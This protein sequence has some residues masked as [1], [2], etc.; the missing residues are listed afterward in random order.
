MTAGLRLSRPF[1]WILPGLVI[2]LLALLGARVTLDWLASRGREKPGAAAAPQAVVPS[3]APAHAPAAGVPQP[4]PLALADIPAPPRW[5]Q[6]AATEQFPKLRFTLDLDY[7]APLGD[8][9]A[10]AAVWFRDFAKSDGSRAADLRDADLKTVRLFGAEQKVYPPD[11]PLLREAEPWVD[12]ATCRFYPGIWKPAGIETP[13][14]NLL[15]AV[16]LARSWAARGEQERDPGRAREDFRRAIRLGRLLMQDDMTLIQ[17]LVGW[18]CVSYGLSGLNE[19]ARRDGDAVMVAA[20]TLA[21]GDYNAMRDIASRWVTEVRIED[22]FREM[23]WGWNVSFEDAQLD[24][25]IERATSDSLRCLRAEALLALVVIEHEGT[26]GQ[27][28]KAA[29]ALAGLTRDPDAQ[30][31]GFAKYLESRAYDRRSFVGITQ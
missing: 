3:S 10:N 6:I 31:A 13:V 9:P 2:V 27:K 1:H 15:F 16:N 12:Q 26:R 25:V 11:H 29:A 24:R 14:P 17:H 5:A 18:A 21:L 7:F 30:L 20:T 19:A 4:K 23:W 28:A 22:A 8:G